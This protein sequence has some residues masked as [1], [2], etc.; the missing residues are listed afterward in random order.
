MTGTPARSLLASSQPLD[1]APEP[2]PLQRASATELLILL[3]AGSNQTIVTSPDTS[4]PENLSAA[5][6]SVPAPTEA[7]HAPASSYYDVM[8][9]SAAS[10]AASTPLSCIDIQEFPHGCEGWRVHLNSDPPI[11]HGDPLDVLNNVSI[12]RVGRLEIL[13]DVSGRKLRAFRKS[14]DPRRPRNSNP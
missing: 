1:S 2:F 11:K 9:R 3:R 12:K 4:A 10:T 8:T 14:P 5:V 6:T 13:N 7:R